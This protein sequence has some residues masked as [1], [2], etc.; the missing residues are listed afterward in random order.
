MARR[1]DSPRNRRRALVRAQGKLA[2]ARLRLAA[3]EPGGSADRPIV[4]PS[5][6][7]V[8]GHA[9]SMPCAACG[10]EVRLEEHA[11]VGAGEDRFRVAKVVCSSCGVRRAVWFTIV[12]PLLS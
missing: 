2:D 5:A 8:D 11:A 12:P 6:S 7:V 4:V 1:K 10:A 3:V 9:R